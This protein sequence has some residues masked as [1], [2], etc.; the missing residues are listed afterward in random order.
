MKKNAS[1]WFGATLG[2]VLAVAFV[3]MVVNLATGGW[4]MMWFGWGHG[5]G[6]MGPWMMGPWM[7]GGWISQV[8]WLIVLI[9]FIATLGIWASRSGK[10]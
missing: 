3:V 4:G 10:K 9:A 5:W 6:M 2:A 7:M 8:F 1:W